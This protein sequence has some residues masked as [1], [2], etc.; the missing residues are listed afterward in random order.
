MADA[1]EP[2]RG[3]EIRRSIVPGRDGFL[4]HRF[5]R[6]F[7]QVCGE[8]T[9]APAEL[10]RWVALLEKRHDWCHAQGITYAFLVA[11]EKHVVYEDK[12][13]EG[14][15]VSPERPVEK[16]L[17]A[18]EPRLR[19]D[20]V[21]PAAALKAG[22]A[23]AETYYRTDVHWTDYGAYLAYREL[24]KVLKREIGIEPIPEADLVRRKQRMV[25]DLGVRLDPEPVEESVRVSHGRVNDI[26]KVY[27]NQAFGR[28]QVEVFESED[29]GL[30]RGVLFRDSNATA[31]LPFLALHFS[32]LVVV[33]SEQFFD[34]LVR[35]ER[36]RIV[37]TEMTERYL[38][39]PGTSP[40]EGEI[41][42]PADFEPGGFIASTGVALPLPTGRRD[43]SVDFRV[44]GDSREFLGEGWSVQEEDHVWAL[45]RESNLTIPLRAESAD[46]VL[47]LD[48][49]G[50]TP[51]PHTAFQRLEIR[52]NGRGLGSFEVGLPVTVSCKLPKE[53]LA[54]ETALRLEFT[55]P[56]CISP[57]EAGFSDDTRLLS[58]ALMAL[59]LRP[60]A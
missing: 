2:D 58:I 50:C 22:R 59:R 18:L 48:V 24:V 28:G 33:S 25:G 7:E 26:R 38:T 52:A 13:P 3:E 27:G 57:K 16:L 47:E 30:P 23:V 1:A 5:D 43:F 37:I 8:R 35:A 42:F 11:P 34:D 56:D 12:L 54:G 55:H 36:P 10:A 45:G 9:L 49:M 46:Y 14:A 4:F 44:G 53:C 19:A 21:Y 31:M 20:V 6:A 60:Q 40:A 32:R 39:F 51:P 41:S 15:A 17:A 29:A